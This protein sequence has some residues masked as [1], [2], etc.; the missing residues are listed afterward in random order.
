MTA[1]F[2]PYIGA[3]VFVAGAFAGSSVVAENRLGHGAQ[4]LAVVSSLAV[5]VG[6]VFAGL[7]EFFVG[8]FGC[9]DHCS[10]TGA[11]QGIP[12]AWQWSVFVWAGI[13]G[14]LISLAVFLLTCNGSHRRARF[15]AAIAFVVYA[16]PLFL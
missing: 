9:D 15:A 12:G 6:G 8:G 5:L 13:V 2:L 3:A 14:A 11:W 1:T 7:Y 16:I 10:G 4:A